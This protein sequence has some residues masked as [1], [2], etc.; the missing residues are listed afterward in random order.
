MYNA[1]VYAV[2]WLAKLHMPP[3]HL[4]TTARASLDEATGTFRSPTRGDAATPAMW[5]ASTASDAGRESRDPELRPSPA[6]SFAPSAVTHEIPSSRARHGGGRRRARGRGW[7]WPPVGFGPGLEAGSG[8]SVEVVPAGSQARVEVD[9]GGLRGG[10]GSGRRRALKRGS[11]GRSP[12]CWRCKS[13]GG[14]RPPACRAA[15]RRGGGGGSHTHVP[16]ARIGGVEARFSYGKVRFG[17]GG[18]DLADAD[19]KS[20]LVLLVS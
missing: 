5:K 8:A 15:P 10:G 6:K 19:L 12:P 17:G 13:R 16:G 7:I 4:R 1:S 3:S 14:A 20:V 2:C 18:F 11:R 9:S